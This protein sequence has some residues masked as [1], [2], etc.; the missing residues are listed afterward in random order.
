MK[1]FDKI[2]NLEAH[3]LPDRPTAAILEKLKQLKLENIEI[4]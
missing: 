4:E 1:L 3:P 2:H